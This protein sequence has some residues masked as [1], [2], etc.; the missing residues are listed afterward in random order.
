MFLTKLALYG[1]IAGSFFAV[2]AFSTVQITKQMNKTPV[3]NETS[4][5]DEEEEEVY[6]RQMSDTERFINSLTGFGNMEGN[7][8][9]TLEKGTYN[10]SV[11]G[12]VFVSMETMDDIRVNADLDIT[13]LGKTFDI[14]ATYLDGTI[15]TTIEG[16]NLK[17]ETSDINEIAS[18]FSTMESSIELPEAFKNI[19]PNQLIVNLSAMTAEKGEDQITY[20]CNLIEG[21]PPI[22]F[23]SD[24]E[25]KMTSVSLSNFEIEGFKINVNATTNILGKGHNKVTSPETEENPYT[26]ITSYF[27]TIKQ[28]KELIDAKEAGLDYEVRLSKGDNELLSTFGN[29]NISLANG[30]D[31]VVDGRMSALGKSFT[32]FGGFQNN[33]IFINYNDL[34]KVS[35]DVDHFDDLKASIESLLN[36]EEITNLTSSLGSIELPI[37]KMINDK[38]YEGLVDAYKGIYLSSDQIKLSISNSL[39]SENTSNIDITINLGEKGITDL[40]IDN[41][42]YNDYALSLKVALKDYVKNEVDLSAYSDFSNI[43]KTVDQITNIITNKKIGVSY[44]LALSKNDEELLSTSGKANVNYK[45]ELDITVDGTLYNADKSKSM[46]YLGGYQDNKVILNYNDLIKVYYDTNN[47]DELKSSVESLMANEDIAKLMDKVEEIEIPLIKMINDKDYDALLKAYKGINVTSSKIT[48]SLSNSILS[49]NDSNFDITVNL[50]N[51]GISSIEL[52]NLRYNEYALNLVAE[53]SEYEEVKVDLT[54]Y[55]N[56]SNINKVVDQINNLITEKKFN[57]TI[58]NISYGD[59][60]VNGYVQLDLVNNLYQADVTISKATTEEE[61]TTYTNYRIRFEN[62]NDNYYIAYSD[63]KNSVNPNANDVKLVISKASVDFTIES[64]KNLLNDHDAEL[65]KLVDG[66]IDDIKAKIEESSKDVNVLDIIFEDYLKSFDIV[67]DELTNTESVN[68]TVNGSKLG[69]ESDINVALSLDEN[70]KISNLAGNLEIKDKNAEF[71]VNLNDFDANLHAIPLNERAENITEGNANVGGWVGIS[72]ATEVI[73]YVTE[74]DNETIKSTIDQIKDIIDNKQAGLGYDINV[75]KNNN[76]LVFNI[77]GDVDLDLSDLENLENVKVNF[78]GN[79]TNTNEDKS[80]DSDIAI[81]LYEGTVYFDYNDQ[82]KFA[83]SINDIKDLVTIIKDKIANNSTTD[84]TGVL[85]SI[86]PSNGDT[87]S[88]PIISIIK[89]GNY[90]SLINY[91]KNAYKDNNGTLTLVFDGA[92]IGNDDAD[93]S[94]SLTAGHNGISNIT[95]NGLY[96]LGYTLDCSIDVESYTDFNMS[97]EEI[98][99]YTNL[100]YINNMFD[101]IY[102]LIHEKEFKITLN[103]N[104]NLGKGNLAINGTSYVAL[105]DEEDIGI[106]DLTITDTSNK[107][108]N[109]KLDVDRKKTGENALERS[110]VAFIYNNNLKGKF[111][112]GSLNESFNLIKELASDGNPL[113][114][115]IKGLLTRDTTQN[116]LSKV[117]NGEPEAILYDNTL[118]SITHGT[119]DDGTHYYDIQING[120]LFKKD[121]DLEVSPIHILINMDNTNKFTG[122]TLIGSI[123]GYSL[124][125]TAGIS[126]EESNPSTWNRIHVDNSFFDFSDMKTLINYLFNTATY[127]DFTL[128]GNVHVDIPVL[129][130]IDLA[131]SAKI[132]ID[133][134][135]NTEAVVVIDNIPQLSVLGSL[136]NASEDTWDHRTFTMHLTDDE[137]TLF[138]DYYSRSSK[139]GLEKV[140]SGLFDYEWVN[141]YYHTH[142]YKTVKLTMEQ[143][144]NDIAYYLVNFG[145]GIKADTFMGTNLDMRQISQNSTEKDIDLSKLLTKYVYRANDGVYTYNSNNEVTGTIIE[146]PSW[147]L[148]IS[149]A[150]LAGTDSNTLGDLNAR[151]YGDST[152]QTLGYVTANVSILSDIVE[153]TL[154]ANVDSFAE[155]DPSTLSSV[156]EFIDSYSNPGYASE[157]KTTFKLEVSSNEY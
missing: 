43:D 128:S 145:I 26:N 20:T 96:A 137:V 114:D 97:E 40:R 57:L 46:T 86:L 155:I 82:L 62:D 23:T 157:K 33:N 2:S 153:A 32:Y 10:L 115:K 109:I 38:D 50:G 134:D 4:S 104:V 110:D 3:P 78:N 138:V 44:N 49:N 127:K 93:I 77:K 51:N 147:E 111:N 73:K 58:N 129:S 12:D 148:G 103:G 65:T 102:E 69:L 16:N 7:L 151:I 54:D 19:N 76:E 24:L 116:T 124:D 146:G 21:I 117:M 45:D 6:V 70:T 31:V 13:T 133:Q 60:A 130:D 14:K 9:L 126:K 149:L 80:L 107:T 22:I 11:T 29:A 113:L 34:I 71:D 85:N 89:E 94:I 1:T 131:L 90:L 121:T 52:T 67:K 68:V 139:G 79:M 61:V 98:S 140:G 88:A 30:L 125:I 154:N 95:I 150:E 112:L 41:F 53:V 17:L 143:F 105:S 8:N 5:E 18:M 91:Y 42:R 81:K 75:Y 25:Y 135:N 122:I 64:V 63:D 141:H 99:G 136:I 15:Y 83:Y 66:F 28:I 48:L 56:I 142:T 156:K 55:D 74:L 39:F 120:N 92:L 59:F 35:Y 108:H 36:V 87:T 37:M 106:A 100:K 123:N 101:Q 132:H 152:D 144:T 118:D 47:F 84:L 27:G 72:N 119:K